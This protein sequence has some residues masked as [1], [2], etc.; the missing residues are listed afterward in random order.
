MRS[1][2]LLPLLF[3]D[4]ISF[5]IIAVGL[6]LSITIHEFSHAFVADKLGDPTPRYQ[7]RVTLDPR[8]HLDPLG[9][10]MIVLIGFGWGKP[11]LFDP[12]NLKDPVKDASLIA[13]AGPASNIIISIILS[14]IIGSFSISG[15]MFYALTT[16]IYV[17]IML[18]IFNLIPI[19]PLD[20]GKIALAILPKQLG[21]EFDHFMNRYG[22]LILIGLLIPWSGSGSPVSHL[23]SPIISWVVSILSLLW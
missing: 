22:T 7:G 13:L 19:H 9:T 1:I 4:P 16:V 11:V 21:L 5:V 10:I 14:L 6:V 23:I 2:G 18:A 15:F 20:G 8:S 3:S 12:Y 17:N